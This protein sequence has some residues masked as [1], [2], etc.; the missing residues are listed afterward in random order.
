[1]KR[2]SVPRIRL[3]AVAAARKK[4]AKAAEALCKRNRRH[5]QIKIRHKRLL[6]R[7]AVDITCQNSSDDSSVDHIAVLEIPEDR[8]ILHDLRNLYNII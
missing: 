8:R 1:M 3:P 4:A 2:D 5:H 6:F 7:A